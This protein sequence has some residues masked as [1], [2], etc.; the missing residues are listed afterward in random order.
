MEFKQQLRDKIFEVLNSWPVNDQYAIMFFIYPNEC[1][2]YGGYNNIPEFTMLYKCESELSRN[3]HSVGAMSRNEERWNPAFWKWGPNKADIIY[4]N[5]PN[6]MADALL[7]WYQSI[8][9]HDIGYEEYTLD[10]HNRFVG[11]GPNGLPELLDLITE[12]ANELQTENIIESKFGKRIPIIL[13]D[14][15]FT[16]YMVAA[17]RL[18]NPNG[19]A[20]DYIEACINEGWVYE[21]LIQ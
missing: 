1:N 9:V 14:F 15:E 13:A 16:W 21:E 3:P 2:E 6:P 17:T 18:A 8:N 20:D 7:S 12:I 10:S 19:E 11:K 4:F 5:E